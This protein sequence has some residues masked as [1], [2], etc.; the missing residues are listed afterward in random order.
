MLSYP[1]TSVFRLSQTQVGHD[2]KRLR[3]V[4]SR[5]TTAAGCDSILR[6]EPPSTTRTETEFRRP[7]FPDRSLETRMK[8]DPGNERRRTLKAC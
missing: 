7:P 1:P 5:D 3:T 6:R 2:E 8:Q 4:V